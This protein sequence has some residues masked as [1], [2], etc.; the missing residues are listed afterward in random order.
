MNN[1]KVTSQN[2]K[3]LQNTM[4]VRR[5][6]QTADSGASGCGINFAAHRLSVSLSVYRAVPADDLDGKSKRAA[7]EM[8]H[9]FHCL[10]RELMPHAPVDLLETL[11][12]LCALETARDRLELY[13]DSGQL[14]GLEKLPLM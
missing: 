6:N 7:R 13:A 4:S 12:E 11:T 3:S 2:G 10:F 8:V 1:K 14:P 9:G 5:A